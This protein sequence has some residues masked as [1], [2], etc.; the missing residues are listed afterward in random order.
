MRSPFMRTDRLQT[1]WFLAVVPETGSPC[2]QRVLLP[3]E[4]Q[5]SN[6]PSLRQSLIPDS[7]QSRPL[8]SNC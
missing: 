8:W 3:C 4:D 5:E 2:L 7:V 1:E 6:P